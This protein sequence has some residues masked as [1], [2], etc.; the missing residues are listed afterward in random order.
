VNRRELLQWM[1]FTGAAC[2]APRWVLAAG[3]QASNGRHLISIFLR[4]AADGLT[5]CA[6][7]ADGRYFDARPTLALDENAALDL[8]GFFGLHPAAGGLKTLFDDGDLAMIHATGLA[9]AQRS[10]F[11]AQAAMELGIDAFDLAPAD[12]WLGRYLAGIAPGSPLSAVA[13]DKAVPRAMAGID[14]ALALG[15]ID[16]F[17]LQLDARAQSA[18]SQAYAAD[19]L[20][21]PTAEA[22]LNA[23]DALVPI[24]EL[25]AGE[26]YPEGPLGTALADAARLIRG[27][28][29]LVAASINAGGWDH[30]DNQ[31]A[32][33]E[34]L[35]A[36]LGDALAAF[37][38]D[39]GARWADTTVIIQTEFGRRLYE[40][41]SAGTDHGHGG[42]ML[43][44]GGRV[45]GG[46]VHADWPGLA[47]RDLSSGEDLAVTTD[48]RLVLGEMLV[49]QFG[50]TDIA[51][52]FPG[53]TPGPWPGIFEPIG[54][55]DARVAG[56]HSDFAQP[57][58]RTPRQS[59]PG[60]TR[61][62]LPAIPAGFR[63]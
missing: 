3:G 37:R 29:G 41:A 11:E 23:A 36:Q 9:S 51:P 19:P 26:D 63:P 28:S 22:A 6:P 49:R 15:A 7:L 12:G 45:N 13:L 4:G 55:T 42:V 62:E 53:W 43:A 48:Y 16:E 2:A 44:A 21:A 14:H 38:A 31:A 61:L 20:L 24:S 1:A 46:S 33:I 54:A 50:V 34:P 30:H 18:L 32:Q 59:M 5:L 60:N 17:S 8:D 35:L 47:P 10:H 40:N 52:I 58:R 57:G 27:D 25:P 39:L 56:H